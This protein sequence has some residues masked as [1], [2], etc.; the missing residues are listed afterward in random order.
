MTLVKIASFHSRLEAETIGHALDQ[1][2]I[3]FLVRSDDLAIFG[4][5]HIGHTPQGATLWVPEDR[6]AEVRELLTCVFEKP[7]EQ[8]EGKD[9]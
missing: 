5:G 1:F 8:E 7:K 6:Q 3:P 9:E 4:P 2:G